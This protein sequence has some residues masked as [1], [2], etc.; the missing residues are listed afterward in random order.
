MF[1]DL[2]LYFPRVSDRSSGTYI[3]QQS[4]LNSSVISFGLFAISF[5]LFSK[6]F[7]NA[8]DRVKT[9]AL[10]KYDVRTLEIN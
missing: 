10:V 7:Q 6:Q 1:I 3:L 9:V 2:R 4:Q 8:K 5:S